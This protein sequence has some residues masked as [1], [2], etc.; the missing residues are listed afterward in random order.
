[1]KHWLTNAKAAELLI[2][3]ERTIKRWM[4]RP[5]ARG[6]LGAVRHGKQWR[7]PLPNNGSNWAIHADHRLRTAGV[8]KK[9][10]WG[11]DLEKCSKHC[12][13]YLFES[14]RLWLA[15]YARAVG[16]GAIT[17]EDIME[18]LLL[19]QAACTILSLQPEKAEADKLKSKFPD[20]LRSRNLSESQILSIMSR[21]PGEHYF[22]KIRAADTMNK[23][24]KIRRGF[25]IAQAAKT[26]EH[27]GK[28]PTAKNLRPLLHKNIMEHIND[29]R[30]KLPGIVVNNPTPEELQS[31]TLASV[32]DQ[33]QGKQPPLVLIDLRRPQRG[34]ALRTFRERHPLRESPQREIV[35]TVYGTKDSIPSAVDRPQIGKS[36]A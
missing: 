14:Y 12:D 6:A 1:M 9:P 26:C 13:R 36:T 5:A 8:L 33:M 18:I 11:R 29:T 24:E 21:W 27:L 7:I 10:L 17:Q 34:L 28:K 15:T 25:D 3:G 32:C 19:W 35:A 23:L 2:V 4:A 16:H 20:Q 30:D 31:I 22:K